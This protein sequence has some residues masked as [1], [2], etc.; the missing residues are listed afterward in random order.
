MKWFGYPNVF[1]KVEKPSPRDL[2]LPA[3]H[4]WYRRCTENRFCSFILRLTFLLLA[5][6]PLFRIIPQIRS[7]P[8]AP[9]PDSKIS[10]TN[11]SKSSF[12]AFRSDNLSCHVC[13]IRSLIPQSI[14]PTSH[15][16][17]FMFVDEPIDSLWRLAK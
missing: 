10:L 11:L 13:N 17:F 14:S 16:V 8:Y 1:S 12:L 7:A 6:N 2:R 4:R 15:R 5:W 9:R 3:R